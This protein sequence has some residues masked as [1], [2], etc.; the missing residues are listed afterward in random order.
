MLGTPELADDRQGYWPLARLTLSRPDWAGGTRQ[1]GQ[2]RPLRARPGRPSQPDV[3]QKGP[4]REN[5]ATWNERWSRGWNWRAEDARTKRLGM[6][7]RDHE[8]DTE[9]IT[10]LKLD[11][12]GE[13]RRSKVRRPL[14]FSTRMRLGF[15]SLRPATPA[16]FKCDS[17]D[18]ERARGEEAAARATTSQ[19]KTCPASSSTSYHPHISGTK[20]ALQQI[21]INCGVAYGA[22][23]EIKPMYTYIDHSSTRFIHKGRAAICQGGYV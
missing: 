9:A 4:R 18:S 10:N 17:D 22:L 3:G 14:R 12:T 20:H 13:L 1:A 16:A 15:D 21:E 6:R 23:R 2:A 19:A 8:L 5:E 11:R 7:G